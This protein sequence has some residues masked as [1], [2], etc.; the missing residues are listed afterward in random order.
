MSYLV[1]KHSHRRLTCSGLALQ[2][3]I[4]LEIKMGWR[5]EN[6]FGKCARMLSK[7]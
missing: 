6:H 1:G 3:I 2:G 5:F 7:Q 4:S